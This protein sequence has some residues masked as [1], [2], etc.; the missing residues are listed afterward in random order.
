MAVYSVEQLGEADVTARS[1][2][3]GEPGW[4]HDRRLAGW[5]AY[6]Q[7]AMPRLERTTLRDSMLTGFELPEPGARAESWDE[8]DDELRRH[9]GFEAEPANIVVL[10]NGYARFT[11]LASEWAEKGVI[12]GSLAEAVT[13]GPEWLQEYLAGKAVPPTEDKPWALNAALWGDGVFLYVPEGVE[14]EVPL[15]TL[16]WGRGGVGLFDRT[17]VVAG[18]NSG[19][20][21]VETVT[22]PG[23]GGPKLRAGVVEVYARD[24]ARVK[25]CALQTLGEDVTN[26]VLR[27]AVLDRNASIQWVVGEFGSSLTVGLTEAHLEG[28]G[29]EASNITVFFADGNQHLDVE[30]RMFHIGTHTQSNILVKGAAKGSGRAVYA[31][32]TSMEDNADEAA[33]FQRGT[34]LLLDRDARAYSLPQLFV[35][36]EQVA[37][38][39]H[40]ATIG[41]VDPEQVFYLRSRGLTEKQA[42]NLLVTGF[43]HPVID[44][45]PIDEVKERLLNLIDRKLAG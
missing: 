2:Q 45:V 25:Y 16:H 17:L 13:R 32:I 43:F 30:P 22:S 23:Q 18:P 28:L 29:A 40:A 15:Q 4:L 5:K 27:R 10:D 19:V 26:L 37:G 34:T 8:M 41:R 11:H 33:A 38:A 20:T 9:A 12:F 6:E 3:R 35:G 42:V 7:N 1:K 44:A 14:I 39:G 36:E 21:V 31:P 24:G